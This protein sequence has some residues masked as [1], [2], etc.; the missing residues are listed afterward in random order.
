SRDTNITDAKQKRALLLYVAGPAV[1]KIINTYVFRAKL[2]REPTLTLEKLQELAR[3]QETANRHASVM[4]DE[5]Y[6]KLN[7]LTTSRSRSGDQNESF[8]QESK[9]AN[10]SG[11]YTAIITTPRETGTGSSANDDSDEYTFTLTQGQSKFSP[12][13]ILS[14]THYRIQPV[15]QKPR[16]VPFHLRKQV[17]ARIEELEALDIIERASGPTSWVSPVVAAPKPH[18]PSE[19]RVCGDYRQPNRAIIRERHPIPTVEELMEDMT[20]ACVFSELDL[21]AGY[22]QIELEEESRSV[23]TFCT[24]EGLLPFCISSASEVFQNV[25]QQSLQSLH[26]VRNI[27]DDLIVWGKSQEE[28]DRNLEKVEAIVKTTTPQ[29][30]AQLQSFLGLAN[31]CARFIK[32]F[33][34]LSAPLNEL[35]K[36]STK[37]Q[38][39]VIHQQ[40]F[41]KIKTAIAEDCSMA[42][43]DP[44]KETTLTVD[45][46]PVGLEVILSQ[47]QKDGTIRNIS[48]ASRTLT[49]TERR[50]SQTEKEVLAVVWGCE[51]FHLYLVGNEFTL[52]TDHKPL[53]LI[54]SPKSKPPPCIERWLLRMQQYLYQV[55]YRPGSSNPAD[56]LSRKPTETC[57]WSA[58]T[59][60]KYINFIE[61]HAVP[62]SMALEEIAAETSTDSELQAVIKAVQTGHWYVT[63]YHKLKDELSITNNGIL[64]RDTRI[65]I[66]KSLQSRTLPIG[67][68]EH[69]GI[70]K[71]KALLRTKVWWP[72]LDTAVE[73][74]VKSC[75]PCQSAT[76]QVPQPKSP[77]I[78]TDMPSKPWSVVY[79]D[80]CGPFPT[81]ETVLVVIDG[82]SRYVEVEIMKSTT[83]T[84]IVSRLKKIFARHGY[85]DELTSDNGPPF[86]AA[87]F[88]AFL[89]Q[90]GV[91]HRKITPYWPQ[92]N[93]E[94]E[95]FM[96]TLEKAARAAHIEGR[97][98]QDELDTFLLNYRSTPHCTTGISP[99]ELLFNRKIRNKL[100]SVDRLDP[101]PS[102]VE[103]S[104]EKAINND[105]KRKEK[106]KKYADKRNHAKNINLQIR[107]YALVRQQKKN[108]I[109]TPFGKTPYRVAEIKGTM[110][111]ATSED[112]GNITRNVSV[113]KQIPNPNLEPQDQI[114]EDFHGDMPN[115]ELTRRYPTRNRRS[116]EFYNSSQT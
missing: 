97:R 31:Y 87:D 51:R 52:Q 42:F 18:D 44:A 47:I 92:A 112:S 40:A 28:H 115:T 19:V 86:N 81:G 91:R 7:R 60:D 39:T 74:L 93:A 68:E 17:S 25:L 103:D 55:Q 116:P 75:L 53:E 113:F 30:V 2:L 58:N 32:D 29:N 9:T 107:E 84:A 49:P 66:P 16:R 80:F 88:D 102:D 56:G 45:A 69:Q 4:A 36:K 104:H 105:S 67:H 73:S 59:A 5:E 22:H 85:P 46:S 10:I 83:T 76:I 109:S 3:A 99:A 12:T 57:E 34:T 78:M 89:N 96:C 50:Y 15:A 94:A 77:L 27:A 38:W 48:Y 20:G 24:H 8:Q 54:Y 11:K 106:M 23:T 114:I 108:K 82:Y 26:G 110:I 72:G 111:I 95:R 6:T 63:A 33:A 101:M 61:S 79:A 98:W 100:P 1:H 90:N 65:I 41:Q 35:T 62:K 21:R 43:Y 37:W 13:K 70:A 64:L 14:S 71:T